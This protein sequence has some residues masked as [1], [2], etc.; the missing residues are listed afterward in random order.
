MMKEE[1]DSIIINLMAFKERMTDIENK[2]DSTQQI[3]LSVGTSIFVV[4]FMKFFELFYLYTGTSSR[5]D[6]EEDYEES[7]C[8][9]ES[10][11]LSEIKE[12][13]DGTSLLFG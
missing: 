5:D 10:S 6:D 2:V 13:E 1:I 8:G 7:L 11:G 12:E 9:S 4:M 3:I